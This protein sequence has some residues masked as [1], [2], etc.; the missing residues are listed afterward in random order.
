MKVRI[1]V[2]FM[3]RYLAVSAE[4]YPN[5]NASVANR[6]KM[7][8]CSERAQIAAERLCKFCGFDPSSILSELSQAEQERVVLAGSLLGANILNSYLH[9]D[10]QAADFS[11]MFE[12]LQKQCAG[13]DEAN[14]EEQS[15]A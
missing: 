13:V 12:M 11:Q 2:Y 6:E 5:H 14:S 9:I 7:S 10:V 1:L 8:E 4:W 15:D 3:A